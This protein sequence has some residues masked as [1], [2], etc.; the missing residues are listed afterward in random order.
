V[1]L[2]PVHIWYLFDYTDEFEWS[3]AA[4]ELTM[5]LEKEKWNKSTHDLGFMLYCSFGNGYRLTGDPFY[6]DVLLTGAQ[7]LKT[8]FNSKTGCIKSWESNDKWQYPV[9]IV[10]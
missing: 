5:R 1:G 10:I 6:R 3:D 7:S 2:F 4:R 9:I 8:R